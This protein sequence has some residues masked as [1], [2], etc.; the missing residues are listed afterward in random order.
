MPRHDPAMVVG[1]PED[2]WIRYTCVVNRKLEEFYKA[3]MTECDLPPPLNWYIVNFDSMKQTNMETSYQRD[4]K[5]FFLQPPKDEKPKN[6]IPPPKS[7]D[8][9]D[10]RPPPVP[11]SS[12]AS[13]VPDHG[14]G[15]GV[16]WSWEETPSQMGRHN[17]ETVESQTDHLIRYS[18][19]ASRILENAYQSG[20]MECRPIPG[21][22]VD[23]TIRDMQEIAI[24]TM[25][26]AKT[27]ITRKFLQ[28]K[29]ATGWK[30]DVYR[31]A[32]S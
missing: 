29:E 6:K 2:C 18:P 4:V 8:T 20:Q 10:E 7:V 13:K 14:T 22:V 19:E 26:G 3:K 15:E 27:R 25:K 32:D 16:V 9:G 17:L 23:L 31:R 11:R 1:D 24:A 5:R 12:G 21:Y 28:I 30:R